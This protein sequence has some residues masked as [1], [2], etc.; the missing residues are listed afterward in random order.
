MPNENTDTTSRWTQ[1][2]ALVLSLLLVASAIAMPLLLTTGLPGVESPHPGT[3]QAATSNETVYYDDF[4]DGNYDD[5]NADSSSIAEIS[6]ESFYGNNSLRTYEDGSDSFGVTWE[7]GPTFD[8][9]NNF[10]ITGTYKPVPDTSS[11]GSETVSLGIFEENGDNKAEIYHNGA[12]GSTYLATQHD[13]PIPEDKIGSSFNGKWVNFR[14]QANNGFARAKIWDA[15]TE[16]PETWQLKREFSEFEGKLTISA[17]SGGTSRELLLDEIDAGGHAITGQFVDQQGDPIPN[18][19]VEGIGVNYN[20][21]NDTIE[22]KE[23]EAEDLLEK[24]EDVGLPD[25]W[26]PNYDLEGHYD[27]ADTTYL[28]AHDASE[29]E[30]TTQFVTDSS[31]LGAPVLQADAGQEIVLSLWDPTEDTG[32]LSNQIDGSYPGATTSGEIVIEQFGPTGEITNREVHETETIAKTTGTNIIEM[33]EYPGVKTSLPTGVYRA[34]PKGNEAAGYSFLVGSPKDQWNVLETELENEANQLTAHAQEIRNNV[35]GGLFERRTTT[36]DAN[37][38]FN[39]RMQTG[40]QKAKIQAYRG[41]GTILT[42]VAGPSFDDLRTAAS[43]GYNGTYTIAAP[44]QVAVPSSNITIE[45][46]RTDQLPMQNPSEFDSIQDWLEEQRLDQRL[47]DLQSQYD[48]Q[49]SELNSSTLERVYENHKTLTETI[50]GAQTRYL[51]RSTYEEIQNASDLSDSQ[52]ATETDHMQVALTGIDTI[53]PQDLAED[54]LEVTDGTINLEYPLP[55]SVDPETVAPELHWA[56]GTVEPIGDE[57]Y[58]VESSGL[59]GQNQQLVIN[60]LPINESDPAAFDVRIQAASAGSDVVAGVGGENGGLLD[61]R[62]SALNPAF[63]GTIPSVSAI[64]VSTLAPGNSETV[65]LTMRTPSDSSF[66]E[67]QSLEAFGPDGNSITTNVTSTSSARFTTNGEGKHFVRVTY[68]D[69]TGSQFVK[70]FSVRALNEGRSD[71]PTVRAETATGGQVYALAGDGLEDA[72]IETDGVGGLDIKAVVPGGETPSSVHVKP[73]AAMDTP[74]T[75]INVRVLEGSDEATVD[76]TVETVIHLYSLSEDAVVWRGNPSI[77]GEPLSSDG[78]TRYGE[79]V[80]RSTD[81]GEKYIIRTYSDGD[82]SV[83]LTINE[84]PGII[85]S[86]QHSIAQTIPKPNIPLLSVSVLGVGLIARRRR[87]QFK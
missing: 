87:P 4:E 75:N 7:G 86:Y 47:A 70:T 34:Y 20:S 17:G 56:D 74:A 11:T 25:A 8:F 19:T 22:D 23:A 54:A 36:T 51:N 31:Q 58:S 52:L 21:I 66:G 84:Q 15:G 55:D 12:D 68:T 10:E 9:S 76:T 44:E 5:W 1:V 65:S 32:I 41:D 62:V 39:L 6:S 50:P 46:Y 81:D 60:D 2:R 38:H 63:G 16:E 82:G 53:E 73:Q 26:D 3:A 30:T 40:V 14:L 57:Y 13:D 42:S 61:D 18:A 27:S 78:G 45:G 69:T 59:A 79:V 35:E 77:F 24:A 49:L 48:Q 43:A 72:K 33:N 29:W 71:P 80:T 67:I 28:L 37:G 64:D 85:A 83:S